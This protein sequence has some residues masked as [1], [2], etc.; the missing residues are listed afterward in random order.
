MKEFFGFSKHLGGYNRPVEG[1][2]S[3]QH[4]VFITTCVLIMI[5]FAVF[6]GLR[7]RNKEMKT[8]NKVLIWTAIIINAFEIFKIILI[9]FRSQNAMAWKTMLPLFLCSLQLIAIP[10]A[11]ASKGRLKDAALDF[12]FIYGLLGALLGTYG[13]AQLYS[14]FPVLSF[15]NVVSA[16]THC[17]AGF[18]SLYIVISGMTSMKPKNI[19]LNFLILFVLCVIAYI[20]NVIVPYNYMFLMRGEGT[21]YDIFYNLVGGSPVL[22]PMVV[23]LLFYM[24]A[25]VFYLIYFWIRK[26]KQKKQAQTAVILEENQPNKS[27]K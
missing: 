2:L 25:S 4:I 11:A 5:G 19:W 6:L 27:Q 22:Y 17:I 8:K 3:W 24:Y 1:F 12:V 21:P 10:I 7:N 20:A 16:I 15:D 9:C 13:A 23:I 14:K 18:A 26:R